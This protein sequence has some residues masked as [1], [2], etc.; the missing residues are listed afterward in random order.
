MLIF[1]YGTPLVFL[2]YKIKEYIPSMH[3][4]IVATIAT[5]KFY[6]DWLYY[7]IIQFNAKPH[8]P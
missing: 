8:R 4:F 6:I 5:L 7:F 3:N 2:K 1:W